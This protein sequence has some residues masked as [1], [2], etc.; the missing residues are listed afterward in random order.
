MSNDTRLG[1][2]N[3][4]N[5]CGLLN[6]QSKEQFNEDVTLCNAV[7]ETHQFALCAQPLRPFSG[8]GSLHVV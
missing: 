5:C 7:R 8:C 4:L 6:N 1:V 3:K 2:E